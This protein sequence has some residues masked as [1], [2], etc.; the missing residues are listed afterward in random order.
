M[1]MLACALNVFGDPAFRQRMATPRP[2]NVGFGPRH[3]LVMESLIHH[4]LG[5]HVYLVHA[6]R[7]VRVDHNLPYQGIF[8]RQA[9]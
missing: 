5:Q 3:W 7:L 1:A 6:Q 8:I 4:K 9:C 2:G